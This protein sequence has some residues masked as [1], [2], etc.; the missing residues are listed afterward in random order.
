M[1]EKGAT[2][3]RLARDDRRRQLLEA[4]WRLVREEGADALSLGRLAEQAGVTKPLVYDHFETRNGLLAVL[5]REYDARQHALIDAALADSGPTLEDKAE[6]IAAT[7]LDCVLL[8][9]GEIPGVSAALAASHELEKVK[10][11]YEG[12]WMEKCRRALA[13]FAVGGDVRPSALWAMLGAAEALSRAA[14]SGRMP[15]IEAKAELAR[16]IVALAGGRTA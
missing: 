8:Q 13:P 5:Y 15:A 11:E 16:A 4:A 6:V 7:Y 9:G 1:G 14:A 3:R 2:R 10:H 12:D